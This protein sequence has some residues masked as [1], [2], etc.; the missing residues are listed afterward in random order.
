M[1][2]HFDVDLSVRAAMQT[3]ALVGHSSNVQLESYLGDEHY[4]V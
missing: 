4:A 2:R 1:H 3:Q